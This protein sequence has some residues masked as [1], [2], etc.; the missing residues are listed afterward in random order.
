MGLVHRDMLNDIVKDWGGFEEFVKKIHQ[1]G[2]VNVIRNV[3]INGKSGA[4]RQIDVLLEQISEPYT[5]KTIIECKYWKQKVSRD[6]IDIINAAMNDVSANK[7]ACFTTI[8]FEEG[9]E[10][11]AKDRGIDLFIIRDLSDEEWGLPGRNISLYFQILTKAI[12][13]IKINDDNM[14]LSLLGNST[15]GSVSLDFINKSSNTI[16]SPHK[17]KYKT[18]EDYL[19]AACN[20][21]YKEWNKKNIAFSTPDITQYTIGNINMPFSDDPVKGRLVLKTHTD[22]IA[23]SKLTI[24]CLVKIEQFKFEYDRATNYEFAIIAENCINNTLYAVSNKKTEDSA[25]WS[26]LEPKIPDNQD[27]VLKNNSVFRISMSG[28]FDPRHNIPKEVQDH[29]NGM[30]YKSTES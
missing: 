11:Y 17:E 7:G 9:A 26:K 6:I 8:G 25:E 18:L 28:F 10:L 27:D 20:E 12:L 30:F 3:T 15:T 13:D 5:Y 24:K 29:I 19:E 2:N 4:K 16:I 1:K 23:I 21:L 22:I 14:A